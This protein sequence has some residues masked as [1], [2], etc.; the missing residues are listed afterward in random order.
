MRIGVVSDTHSKP[1]PAQMVR[2][3]A[4]VDF[5]IHAGDFCELADY[6]AL[7]KIRDVKAV[8]GNM[9]GAQIRKKFPRSQIIPCGRFRVGVFHGE[10]SAHFILETVQREFQGEAVDAVVFGHSHKP[11]NE[12]I[13]GVL[14]F[15]PGSPNDDISAPFCSYGILDV[16]DNGIKASIIKVKK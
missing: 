9:D 12:K 13:G 3:F 11:F 10:G 8:Q 6:E 7:A 16:A 2:D 5:I 14:F 15:N 4:G 1:L